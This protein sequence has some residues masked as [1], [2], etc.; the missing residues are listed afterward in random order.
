MLLVCILA[1]L[2]QGLILNSGRS[3]TTFGTK[4]PVFRANSGRLLGTKWQKLWIYKNVIIIVK[5]VHSECVVYRKKLF[6][7]KKLG[8]CKNDE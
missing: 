5:I 2:S 1:I 8:A 3:Y 6:T 4:I 7:F